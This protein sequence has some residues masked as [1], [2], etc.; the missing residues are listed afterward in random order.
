[1]FAL[2]SDRSKPNFARFFG[3]LF[4]CTNAYC[5]LLAQ[6]PVVQYSLHANAGVFTTKM[7]PTGVLS[8]FY[9]TEPGLNLEL[10]C[11]A[12]CF[13][14]KWLSVYA[15]C[16]LARMSTHTKRILAVLPDSAF[17]DDGLEY[18]QEIW[19]DFH[20]YNAILRVGSAVKFHSKF[21]LGIAFQGMYNLHTT[22]IR[23]EK[24]LAFP[25]DASLFFE[26]Q[27]LSSKFFEKIDYGL[28]CYFMHHINTRLSAAVDCYYTKHSVLD[29]YKGNWLK[30]RAI[31]IGFYYK[32]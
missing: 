16:S 21:S 18:R 22:E 10:G 24:W 8:Y 13:L 17:L 28:H 7:D 11:K 30:S 12:D 3:V 20:L 14:K 29:R 25:V 23:Q 4:F 15:D 26:K 31:N 9:R 19:S 1:M 27:K 5:C 6:K 32:M 2:L